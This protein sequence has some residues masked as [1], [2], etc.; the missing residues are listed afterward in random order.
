MWGDPEALSE[1]P[2][3]S[4]WEWRLSWDQIGRQ[5]QHSDKLVLTAC[6]WVPTGYVPQLKYE[7]CYN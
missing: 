1:G 3:P 4:D 5:Q 7:P 2:R 6:P